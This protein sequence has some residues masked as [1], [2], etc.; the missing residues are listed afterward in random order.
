MTAPARVYNIM[1]V[2][3]GMCD[4]WA[5]L[6]ESSAKPSWLVILAPHKK[7]G[8]SELCT[9]GYFTGLISDEA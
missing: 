2:L 3:A 5:V 7:P 1:D 8:M 6:W 4:V 9:S